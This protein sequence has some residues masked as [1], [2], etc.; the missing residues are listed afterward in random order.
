MSAIDGVPAVTAM[1]SLPWMASTAVK[2][3]FVASWLPGGGA[4]T[5]SVN[6]MSA[7]FVLNPLNVGI[8]M[9]T[10]SGRALR[11]SVTGL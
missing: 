3:Q 10:V 5:R 6:V 11:G 2:I 9:K 4:R 1:S 7:M 8:S